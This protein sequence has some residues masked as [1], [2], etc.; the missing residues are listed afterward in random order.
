LTAVNEWGRDPCHGGV[1]AILRQNDLRAF[2]FGFRMAFKKTAFSVSLPL[3]IGL[4]YAAYR[5]SP[6]RRAGHF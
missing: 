1:Q 5:Y 3:S 6:A 2:R 4:Q